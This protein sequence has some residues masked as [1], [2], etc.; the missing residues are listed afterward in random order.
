VVGGAPERRF[1][2]VVRTYGDHRIAMAFGVLA[3]AGHDVRI[4]EPAATDISF[5]GYWTLLRSLRTGRDTR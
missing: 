3:A 2:G 5:P 1:S 4:D